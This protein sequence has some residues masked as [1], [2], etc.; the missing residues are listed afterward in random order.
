MYGKVKWQSA[1]DSKTRCR[2]PDA[3]LSAPKLLVKAKFNGPIAHRLKQDKKWEH[4][5]F[6]HRMCRQNHSHWSPPQT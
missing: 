1:A 2:I 4:W 3:R 6:L 5:K